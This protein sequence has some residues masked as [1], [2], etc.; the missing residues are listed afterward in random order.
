MA[1]MVSLPLFAGPGRELEEGSELRPGQLRALAGALSDRLGQAAEVLE[2]LNAAG[3]TSR[4]ALYD[5]LLNRPGVETR[6][7]VE[8]RFRE[9]GVDPEKF[10]II[11]DVSEE[12][13]GP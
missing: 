9:A 1:V 13:Q 7:E 3:W 5:A 11:E 12:E 10:V 6:L 2:K 4:V 8:Q